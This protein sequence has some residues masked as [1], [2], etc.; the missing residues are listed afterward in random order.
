[1]LCDW[2]VGEGF[3]TVGYSSG[4]CV[5]DDPSEALSCDMLFLDWMLPGC[6]GEKLL[7]LF[8]SD[9]GYSGAVFLVSSR[10]TQDDIAHILSLGAD[11]YIVKP[12]ARKIVLAR[13]GAV[14]RRT[15]GWSRQVSAVRTDTGPYKVLQE[16]R[17]VLL[18]DHDMPLTRLEF[19][20]ASYLFAHVDD[21]IKR[22][23]LI[24]HVWGKMGDLD[25]RTVDVHMSS[26]RRKLCLRPENGFR[27]V[28]I[29]SLGYRLE[30][31]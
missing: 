19:D 10:D 12:A 27:L 21:L 23:D 22:S 14:L 7:R 29:H 13:V 18:H 6:S 16:H 17:K 9:F 31:I 24:R 25:T 3:A 2:L 11:D 28:S 4:S 26:L 15:T 5:Y 8:R 20:L 1:M 30:R